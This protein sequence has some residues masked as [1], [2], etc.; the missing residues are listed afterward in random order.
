MRNRGNRLPY[1]VRLPPRCRVASPLFPKHSSP[2]HRM[3]R[4]NKNRRDYNVNRTRLRQYPKCSRRQNRN[5]L[6]KSVD[7]CRWHC[8]R[9]HARMA[10]LPGPFGRPTNHRGRRRI[11]GKF[12]DRIFKARRGGLQRSGGCCRGGDLGDTY[13]GLADG[14]ETGEGTVH[15]QP[16]PGALGWA[17]EGAGTRNQLR[18]THG[19]LLPRLCA[20]LVVRRVADRPRHQ[21]LRHRFR[22]H[23]R[24]RH[25]G[26]L[27]HR[28]R[29]LP[30]GPP[31]ALHHGLQQG[32]GLD[33]PRDAG[34]G[35]RPPHRHPQRGGPPPGLPP[36][37]DLAARRRLRLP[38]TQGRAHLRQAQPRHRG[39]HDGSARR[40][41][42]Q[43]QVDRDPAHHAL[44]RPARGLRAPR[45]RQ[46]GR[47]QRAVAAAAHRPRFAGARALRGVHRG[48]RAVRQGGRDAGRGGTGLPHVQRA[49][50]HR[51][52]AGQVRYAVRS[53]RHAAERRAEAAHRHRARHRGEPEDPAARRGDVCAGHGEREARAGCARLAHG[54]P[55]RGRRGA[56][57]LHHPPRRQHR[58]VPEGRRGRAGHARRARRRGRGLH[59]PRVGPDGTLAP[60]TRPAGQHHLAPADRPPAADH[61]ERGPR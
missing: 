44:L 59:A 4:Y 22:L 41:Q 35:P 3:V 12:A 61:R 43:R 52:A 24:R 10:A 28:P 18:H 2:R 19:H 51:R 9:L 38:R 60:R 23:G 20:G 7:I 14:R 25:H 17:Q 27:L 29:Q 11:S 57:A 15:C 47:H 37:R 13:C 54:R 16:W 56:S 26:L 46:P 21:Q 32:A 39:G 58:R 33:G 30:P 55:H 34:C 53:A 36:R 42:R 48:Q 8:H 50:L 1:V 49:R 31:R 40:R 45:R 6:P 5:F